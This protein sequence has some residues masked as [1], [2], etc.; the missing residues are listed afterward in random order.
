MSGSWFF[1]VVGCNDDT[2]FQKHN[3]VL[4]IPNNSRANQKSLTLCISA[5][6]K[7]SFANTG[8]FFFFIREQGTGC[9]IS[10]IHVVIMD[11]SKV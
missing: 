6:L 4:I 2:Q 11:Y 10:G 7:Q 3:K 8:N 9:L 5:M 1:K